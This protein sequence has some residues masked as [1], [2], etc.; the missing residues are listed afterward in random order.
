MPCLLHGRCLQAWQ[1]GQAWRHW[2]HQALRSARGSWGWAGRWTRL[3]QRR[4]GGGACHAPVVTPVGLHFRSL[5]VAAAVLL[6]GCPPCCGRAAALTCGVGGDVAA[7]AGPLCW[8]DLPGA[9]S[10]HAHQAAAVAKVSVSQGAARIGRAAGAACVRAGVGTHRAVVQRR[11][12]AVLPASAHQASTAA[13]AGRR[14]PTGTPTVGGRRQA[15][16]ISRGGEAAGRLLSCVATVMTGKWG[17]PGENLQSSV[18]A[19]RAGAQRGCQRRLAVLLT[20]KGRWALGRCGTRRG[21]GCPAAL[22]AA[23]SMGPAA[24]RTGRTGRRGRPPACLQ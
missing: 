24:G 6:P 15:A 14:P 5:Q 7:E 2:P 17:E 22:R 11:R 4:D 21:R 20:Q 12:G 8:H 1:A 13:P 23:P 18:C 9:L 3:Q 19:D 10:R 16:G